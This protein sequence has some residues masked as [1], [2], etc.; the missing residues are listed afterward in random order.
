[1]PLLLLRLL[2]LPLYRR[3]VLIKIQDL[4]HIGNQSRPRLFDLAIN[5]PEVLY[6]KVIEVSERVTLEAWTESKSPFVL[7][8]EAD[9]ALVTGITGEVVRVLEPL[10]MP[11]FLGLKSLKMLYTDVVRS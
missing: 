9:P 4:L 2:L 5:K 7:G 11:L 6:S 8:D 10:G 3:R 1:L